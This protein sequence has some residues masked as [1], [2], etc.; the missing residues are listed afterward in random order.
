[1]VETMGEL[2]IT[3]G[4][5]EK[6]IRV[7]PSAAAMLG[8]AC[9]ACGLEHVDDN[10]LQSHLAGNKQCR[11]KIHHAR[12]ERLVEAYREAMRAMR[13][14]PPPSLVRSRPSEMAADAGTGVEEQHV[15]GERM[16]AAEPVADGALSDVS[17]EDEGFD[18]LTEMYIFFR[19]ADLS[20]R[21]V[22]RLLT[23]FSNPRF[24]VRDVRRWLNYVDV[25][26]F[27]KAM[28]PPDLVPWLKTEIKC[29]GPGGKMA[30]LPLH[31]RNT[32]MAA[33]PGQKGMIL[34]VIVYSDST[35]ASHNGRLQAW[36][37]L[38]SL[39]NIPERLRWLEPGHVLAGVLPFPPEWATSTEKTRV[40]Q[41]AMA[42][43]FEPLLRAHSG[44]ELKFIYVTDA[45]GKVVKAYPCLFAEVGDYPESSRA[46][47]TMQ[48]RS[49]RPCSGCYIKRVH[50]ADLR[51]ETTVRTPGLHRHTVEAI[52]NAPT[53]D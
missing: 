22:N 14:S 8:N 51:R 23:I 39:F 40:F 17:S 24:S 28:A 45:S 38:I 34:G 41:E 44:A 42:V 50:L 47:A 48:Q 9:E 3:S 2:C 27:G 4:G 10:T 26:R 18:T 29:Y 43:I 33:R 49:H 53:S 19:D 16:G 30:R 37:V 11:R 25:R 21:E 15:E 1:M 13:G 20:R 32:E 52:L 5:G 36:P 6:Q 7:S 35:H 46:T 31:Y 12:A